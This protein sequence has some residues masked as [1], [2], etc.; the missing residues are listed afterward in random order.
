MAPEKQNLLW[1]DTNYRRD[2]IGSLE[3]GIYVMA[4]N[5][6]GF[7][8]TELF[9]VQGAA[10]PKILY[11]LPI[12]TGWFYGLTG[13]MR[14]ESDT[15]IVG[16]I[17]RHSGTGAYRL[18]NVWRQGGTLGFHYVDIE[19]GVEPIRLCVSGDGNFFVLQ[20]TSGANTYVRFYWAGGNLSS[21][22]TVI[23][24]DKSTGYLAG[25]TG[26]NRFI[27]V[28]TSNAS[29]WY[30]I[31]GV[32]GF[33]DTTL[34]EDPYLRTTR[35]TYSYDLS[36]VVGTVVFASVN[37]HWDWG[38]TIGAAPTGG[39]GTTNGVIAPGNLGANWYYTGGT[40]IFTGSNWVVDFGADFGGASGSA[41]VTA[42]SEGFPWLPGGST[43]VIQVDNSDRN[44]GRIELRDET[45]AVLSYVTAPDP[46]LRG[47]GMWVGSG[48]NTLTYLLAQA[49]VVGG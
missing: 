49:G 38:G 44:G 24:D 27:W 40:A 48:V 19:G 15:G 11:H 18:Y 31:T 17:A 1:N 33:W 42:G 16:F 14:A 20:C 8:A 23:S 3:D 47:G 26:W 12:N 39:H 9:L 28:N 21:E 34:V 25:A 41:Y 36:S 29:F 5:N 4:A 32:L 13:T 6:E 30:Y 7:N 45:G 22:C 46:F 10:D 43:Q 35:A 2:I 37:S